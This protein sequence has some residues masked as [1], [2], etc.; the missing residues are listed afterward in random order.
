M[1]EILIGKININP[2]R[3]DI[4]SINLLEGVILILK[5]SKNPTINIDKPMKR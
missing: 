5:S 4:I 2:K 1:L 3:K